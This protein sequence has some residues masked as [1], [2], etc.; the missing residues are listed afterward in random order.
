[1]ILLLEMHDA[2]ALPL[3]CRELEARG[4][5]YHVENAGMHALLPLPG[6]MDVRVLVAE[7]DYDA[8]M[9]I[10]G[11]LGLLQQAPTTT[12]EREET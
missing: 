8:A 2:V 1:M 10:A 6:V 4:I 5:E 11:D 3:L 7:N 9:R 12:G